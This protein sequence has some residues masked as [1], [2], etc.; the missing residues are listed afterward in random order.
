MHC[1]SMQSSLNSEKFA[2][3]ADALEESELGKITVDF[4]AGG[5]F[6]VSHKDILQ[7]P[8]SRY[9]Q[10]SLQRVAL[11]SDG[12]Q[13][14]DEGF[15]LDQTTADLNVSLMPNTT[16]SGYVDAGVSQFEQIKVWC[17]VGSA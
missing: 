6:F 1:V 5:V 14:D 3:N 8:Q 12:D 9:S 7:A 16:R 13:Y 11:G 17:V 2:L 4:F 15:E 10:Q